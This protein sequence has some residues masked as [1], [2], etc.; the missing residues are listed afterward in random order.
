MTTLTINIPDSD[1]SLI[2]QLVEEL[3]GEVV[4]VIEPEILSK[5]ALDELREGL[6]EVK[7]IRQGKLLKISLKEALRD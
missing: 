3:G 6:C 7:A 1:T 5:N 2:S 4:S